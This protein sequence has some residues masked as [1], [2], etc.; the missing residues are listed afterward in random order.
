M[1]ATE[2]EEH[3]RRIYDPARENTETFSEDL[4]WHVPGDNPVSGAYRGHDQYFG[5]M[6]ERMSPLDEWTV[7]VGDVLVNQRDNA[8]LVSFHLTGLRKGVRIETDGFHLVRL[9]EDGRVREGWGF[10]RDQERLDAF[11]SA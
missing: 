7:T 8:A 1:D 4:V 5:T 3:V 10:T 6:V 9:T 2:I 11:F